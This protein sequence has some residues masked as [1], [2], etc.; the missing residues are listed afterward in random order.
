VD[1]EQQRRLAATR[2][3]RLE[4]LGKLESLA[5]V[6]RTYSLAV[7]VRGRIGQALEDEPT[8]NLPVLENER[9]LARAHLEDGPG[10]LCGSIPKP[11]SKKPA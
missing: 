1:S 9:N 7:N 8:D 2:S 6:V 10:G 5:L 3:E 4:V 11:G